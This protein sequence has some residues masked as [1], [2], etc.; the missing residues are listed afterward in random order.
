MT[1]VT[2]TIIDGSFFLGVAVLLL[3]FITYVMI[4]GILVLRA[5]V[6][7]QW[8]CRNLTRDEVLGLASAIV[9]VLVMLMV[10]QALYLGYAVDGLEMGI[11]GWGRLALDASVTWVFLH[12]LQHWMQMTEACYHDDTNADN[13]NE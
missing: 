4:R 9:T 2:T 10:K 5:I 8:V 12:L 7:K 1:P 11:R 3:F 6:D 13:H